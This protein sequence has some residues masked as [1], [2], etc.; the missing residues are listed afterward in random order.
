MLLASL[1]TPV[2]SS[3]APPN[4]WGEM[5]WPQ[6]QDCRPHTLAQCDSLADPYG[7]I[8]MVQ[9]VYCYYCTAHSAWTH[10]VLPLCS[11]GTSHD[12]GAAALSLA[13]R[14]ATENGRAEDLRL[15]RAA[16][17]P[18]RAS[19]PHGHWHAPLSNRCRQPR[20][21]LLL[22]LHQSTHAPAS[23]VACPIAHR[24]LPQLPAW[25]ADSAISPSSH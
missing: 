17:P 1:P 2:S 22:E 16:A 7:L 6:P 15:C 11:Q 20:A 14:F 23:G 24:V 5:S 25:R 19:S 9:T 8:G 13:L 21:S 10:R 4:F 12:G 18:A 3:L